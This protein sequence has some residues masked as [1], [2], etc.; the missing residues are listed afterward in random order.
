[1][2]LQYLI[3]E[4]EDGKRLDQLLS[5]LD[6]IVSRT[7][8]QRL[9]KSGNIL[10]NGKAEMSPSRKVRTGQEIMLTIPPPESTEVLSEAGELDILFEDEHLIVINKAAGMVVHPSAGHHSGTLVNYLL[11]HCQ[12]LSGIGGVLRP[13]IV[14]RLDKDTSGILV[15]AKTDDAHQNLSEQFKEHSV[16]RQYQTMVW[17]VPEKEHGVINAALRRHPVRRKDMSIVENE[18]PEESEREK[19]KY[20]VT[21]W[22]VLQRFEFSALFACRLETGRTHQIR[23]HLTSIGHPVIGDPQY[24]KSPLKRLPS[25]SAELSQTIANFR[26]QALHAEILGFKHP[27]SSEWVEYSAAIPDDFQQ[28]LKAIKHD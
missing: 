5:T 19:G 27:S 17:G 22:R 26:R 7:Q 11:H 10:L 9:L 14:H 25:V 16:K 4:D 6:E 28:L 24:G 12:D 2:K 21:H 13:G 1:M 23:V 15:V 18:N 3:Q 8:A 20:A